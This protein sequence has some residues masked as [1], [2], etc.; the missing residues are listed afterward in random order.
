MKTKHMFLHHIMA[1]QIQ[2]E[3]REDQAVKYQ[4]PKYE[5]SIIEAKDVIAA[6]PDKYEVEEVNGTGKVIINASNIFG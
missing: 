6:S 5:I 1:L 3:E 2:N 4:E